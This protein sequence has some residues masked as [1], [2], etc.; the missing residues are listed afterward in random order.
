MALE[1]SKT[2]ITRPSVDTITIIMQ[3]ERIPDTGAYDT[4]KPTPSSMDDTSAHVI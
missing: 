3:T 2:K 1:M 4:L